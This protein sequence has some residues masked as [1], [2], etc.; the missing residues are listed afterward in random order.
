MRRRSGARRPRGR[1]GTDAVDH[2]GYSGRTGTPHP[3]GHPSP[4]IEHSHLPV[5]RAK[6]RNPYNACVNE[7]WQRAEER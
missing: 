5:I 7:H 6:K 2:A 4:A 3:R 1:E